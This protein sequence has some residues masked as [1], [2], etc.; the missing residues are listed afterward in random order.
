MRPFPFILLFVLIFGCAQPEAG[1]STEAPDEELPPAAETPEANQTPSAGQPGEEQEVPEEPETTLESE[2]IAYS[3]S[4][5]E[6]HATLYPAENKNN[7][8]RI[9]F[10]LPMLGEDRSSYPPDFIEELHDEIPEAIVLAVD[11]RG[12]GESTNLKSWEDMN[13]FEFKA[14]Q[15]DVIDGI[16]Y[17]EDR[18][19]TADEYYVVGASI[20]STAAILA[21]ARERGITKVAMLS[22]GM[23]YKDVSIE[24]AVDEYQ[25]PLLLVAG[26]QDAYS[27]EAIDDIG[28]LSSSDITRK[29][30]Q[31][32]EH[33]TGLFQATENEPEPLDSLIVDFLK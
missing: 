6:I 9:V 26:S 24:S 31:G 19:P 14:M 27:V 10:L 25:R 20:G 4:G 28:E 32:Q 30:Y 11:T 7:P 33:G 18:Y 3:S 16:R 23:E 29:I 17:L 15:N 13:S 12:H 21:G 1:P 8:T 5:W 22:P 2:E